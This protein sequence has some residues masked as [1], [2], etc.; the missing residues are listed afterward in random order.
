VILLGALAVGAH[1]T[2]SNGVLSGGSS[3]CVVRV[4]FVAV[5]LLVCSNFC[6]FL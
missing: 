3:L 5:L 6:G 2:V 4:H 1:G